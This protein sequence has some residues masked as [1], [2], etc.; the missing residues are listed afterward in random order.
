MTD[1]SLL[2][3]V[4]LFRFSPECLTHPTRGSSNGTRQPRSAGLFRLTLYIL[5]FFGGS[6]LMRPKQITL[7]LTLI[8]LTIAF[9]C[10]GSYRRTRAQNGY[11]CADTRTCSV[12]FPEDCFPNMSSLPTIDSCGWGLV[13]ERVGWSL[14]RSRSLFR[15][16]RRTLWSASWTA[17]MYQQREKWNLTCSIAPVWGSHN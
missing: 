4:Q 6:D 3:Y 12:G 13:Y 10:F 11:V 14:R 16:L 2:A 9:L 7:A 5:A 17:S 8:S 1:A 15:S